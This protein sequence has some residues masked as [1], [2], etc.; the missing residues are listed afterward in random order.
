METVTAEMLEKIYIPMLRDIDDGDRPT[1][2]EAMVAASEKANSG[3][4]S[5]SVPDGGTTL[6]A[7]AVVGNLAYVTHVG[8]SRAYLTP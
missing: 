6:T 2:V 1:I 4:L 5:K 7:V 3:M 8:D